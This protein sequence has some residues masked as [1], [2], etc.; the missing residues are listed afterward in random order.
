MFNKLKLNIIFNTCLALQDKDVIFK[1]NKKL[2]SW[3][4]EE[5]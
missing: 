4:K 3:Q 5:E 2:K 1:Y